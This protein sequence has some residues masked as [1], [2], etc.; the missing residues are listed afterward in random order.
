LSQQSLVFLALN[1]E[2]NLREVIVVLFHSIDSG[3]PMLGALDLLCP[4]KS[5]R[6]AGPVR[7]PE[8]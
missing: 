3:H 8:V 4:L 5:R 7:L 2:E 6:G 1:S